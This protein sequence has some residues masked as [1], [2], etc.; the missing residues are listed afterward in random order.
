MLAGSLDLEKN[1]VWPR[2]LVLVILSPSPLSVS[3]DIVVSIGSW[4]ATPLG[5]DL[6]SANLCSLCVRG[7]VVDREECVSARH[8]C[9]YS[10]RRFGDLDP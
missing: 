1:I 8:A 6:V 4:I 7:S 10:S 2:N 9:G 3:L 5:V